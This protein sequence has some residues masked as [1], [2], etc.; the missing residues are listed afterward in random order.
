MA[1]T[2]WVRRRK[3]RELAEGQARADYR[4]EGLV[5]FFKG[6][7]LYP[8]GKEKLLEGLKQDKG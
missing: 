1:G 8:K 4:R 6:F 2:W 3:T 7:D 5:D